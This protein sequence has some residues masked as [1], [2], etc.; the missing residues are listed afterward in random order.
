M[1]NILNVLLVVFCWI[2]QDLLI[3]I[4]LKYMIASIDFWTLKM[5]FTYLIGKKMFNIQIYKHQIFAIY[6]ISIVCSLLFLIL[7][8]I[9][10]KSIFRSNPYLI[11]IGIL[12]GLFNLL[13]E[14]LSNCKAKWLMDLRFISSNKLLMC[15]GI[16]GFVIDSIICTITTFVDCGKNNFNLCKKNYNKKIYL[17]N[18]FSYFNDLSIKNIILMIFYV[19]TFLLKSLF[20]ILTIKYLTPFHIISLPTIYYFL[21]HM[22]L[23]IYTI[24]KKKEIENVNY[25]LELSSSFLAF[26]AF[27]IFLEFIE[28]NFC[29]CNYNL[30]RYIVRRSIIDSNINNEYE[31]TIISEEEKIENTSQS[32]L[33]L[34]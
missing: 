24:V 16:L 17:E 7:L 31:D 18:F 14:S 1:P 10:E 22:V 33:S 4:I 15:Y 30:R 20:Y 8:I 13:I 23:G 28:L 29:L 5:L 32:E 19:I 2:I 6:F 21:V 3:Y 27:S 34:K 25:A 11:P 26:L 9:D 12:I